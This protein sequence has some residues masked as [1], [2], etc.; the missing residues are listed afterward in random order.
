MVCVHTQVPHLAGGKATR[1]N[2]AMRGT[3][4][5]ALLTMA[6]LKDL[7]ADTAGSAPVY[8]PLVRTHRHIKAGNEKKAG[9]QFVLC[10]SLCCG[11]AR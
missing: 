5:N 9:S 3:K 8:I 11:G 10:L 7:A 4:G 1:G 2:A 6:A